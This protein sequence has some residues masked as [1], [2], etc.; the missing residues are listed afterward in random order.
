MRKCIVLVIAMFF[1]NSV[2]RSQTAVDVSKITCDQFILFKVKDPQKIAIWLSGYYNGMQKR[3]SI[4]MNRL[5][6]RA[7]KL[8]DF[9]Y[10]NPKIYVMDAAERVF[11][12]S[13]V[14]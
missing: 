5:E 6:E 8:K 9:C 13:N 14:Q 11:E 10:S 7:D 3:T 12:L 1:L 4:D 2:A